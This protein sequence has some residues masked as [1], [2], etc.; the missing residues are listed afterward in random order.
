MIKWWFVEEDGIMRERK[1]RLGKRK[2][3]DGAALRDNEAEQ[4]S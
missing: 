3:E 2:K 1:K 4:K